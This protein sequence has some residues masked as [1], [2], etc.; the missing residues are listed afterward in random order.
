MKSKL[1]ADQGTDFANKVQ[2]LVNNYSKFAEKNE[3]FF[4]PEY[5]NHG[6][7]HIERVLEIV[8]KLIPD[9]TFE[10]LTYQDIGVIII[11]VVLHDIGM[12]TNVDLFENMINGNYDKVRKSEFGDKTWNELWAVFL[13][14]SKYWD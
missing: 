7:G 8:D 10:K 14:E 5:T 6:I 2:V 4:F 13:K 3:M 12:Q 1:E 11:A 9:N